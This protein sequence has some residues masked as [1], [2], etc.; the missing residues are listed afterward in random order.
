MPVLS[1]IDDGILKGYV[2][3]HKDWTGFS[4]DAILRASQSVM[5]EEEKVLSS[6]AGITLVS[7]DKLLKMESYRPISG[8]SFVD[9]NKPLLRIRNGRLR[10][11]TSCLRLFRDVE[12]E[13]SDKGETV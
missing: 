6:T 13:Y 5:T 11:S 8:T 7:T 9:R 4:G 2:P 1:V 3:I 10:F 12:Y